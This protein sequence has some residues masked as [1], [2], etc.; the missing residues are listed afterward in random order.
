MIENLA[1]RLR[2]TRY[3]ALAYPHAEARQKAHRETTINEKLLL[4]FMRRSSRIFQPDILDVAFFVDRL[5]D[6]INLCRFEFY[7]LVTDGARRTSQLES[8][9]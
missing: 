8:K 4:S 7:K 5:S 3:A 9:I 6:L 1:L 2:S